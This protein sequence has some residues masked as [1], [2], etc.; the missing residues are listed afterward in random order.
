MCLET[1]IN[2]VLLI[3]D[4][5]APAE[6]FTLKKKV[7]KDGALDFKQTCS[8]FTNWDF[9]LSKTLVHEEGIAHLSNK[10]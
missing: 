8:C 10:P 6:A 7:N 1:I 2:I 4:R 5:V 9:L 3:I